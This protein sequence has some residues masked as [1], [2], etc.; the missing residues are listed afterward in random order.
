MQSQQ[1]KVKWSRGETADALEERTDTGITQVSVSKLE[2]I[3]ADIYGN[4][5]RRP[6]LKIVAQANKHPVTPVVT[7]TYNA[8]NFF[9]VV[10]STFVFTINQNKYIIFIAGERY[11]DGFLIEN[12]K[13]VRKVNITGVRENELRYAFGKNGQASFAQSNNW[14]ILSNVWAETIVMRLTDTDDITT[15]IFQFSA[16]W[17]APNGTQTMQVTSNEITG[18]SFDASTIA[19]YTYTE[20]NGITTVYSWINTGIAAST[21]SGV[22]D[23]DTTTFYLTLT[24]LSVALSL[25]TGVNRDPYIIRF[26]PLLA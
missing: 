25:A 11:I 7:Q 9:P 26:V 6:A 21:I 13:F 15:E 18:L 10:P 8:G 23:A 20:H 19:N 12:E 24:L 4:I 17:Y 16:P 14:G 3:I 1:K 2:N 22:W 5:S